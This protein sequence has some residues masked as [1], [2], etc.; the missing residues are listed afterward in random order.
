MAFLCSAVMHL[1]SY[2]NRHTR[3]LLYGFDDDH[4]DEVFFIVCPSHNY[5]NYTIMPHNFLC[6]ITNRDQCNSQET[7]ELCPSFKQTNV[8]IKQLAIK[9]G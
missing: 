6:F 2:R 3:N 8:N 7:T 1:C 4:D 5:Y 9:D